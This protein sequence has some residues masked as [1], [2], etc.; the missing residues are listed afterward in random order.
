MKVECEFLHNL[1][2]FINLLMGS[3]NGDIHRKEKERGEGTKISKGTCE[4]TQVLP[5]GISSGK[6]KLRMSSENGKKM[7]LKPGGDI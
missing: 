1:L 7:T 6:V 5:L 2:S 4:M 3:F